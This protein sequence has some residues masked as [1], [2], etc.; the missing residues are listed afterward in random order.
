MC[1]LF[2]ISK[3]QQII[4]FNAPPMVRL[5]HQ[6]QLWLHFAAHARHTRWQLWRLRCHLRIDAAFN[7][8]SLSNL[9]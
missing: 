9:S 2:A 4:A 1:S 3:W 7:V 6:K 8:A 5:A